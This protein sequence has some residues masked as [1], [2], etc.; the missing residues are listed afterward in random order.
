MTDMQL[1]KLDGLFHSNKGIIIDSLIENE[2][3]EIFVFF[4]QKLPKDVVVKLKQ[5]NEIRDMIFNYF[6]RNCDELIR[7]SHSLPSKSLDI[8]VE[9]NV[10]SSIS[11][12]SLELEET[13]LKNSWQERKYSRESLNASFFT[14]NIEHDSIVKC[15]IRDN[16]MKPRT[17][18]DLN[19]AINLP[20]SMFFTPIFLY[21]ASVEYLLKNILTKYYI[22][23]MDEEIKTIDMKIKVDSKLNSQTKC[24]SQYVENLMKKMKNLNEETID[25][26]SPSFLSKYSIYFD[27]L[28]ENITQL[29]S[30]TTKNMWVKQIQNEVNGRDT[31]GIR[32]ETFNIIAN[33]LSSI[34]D[35][36][37]LGYQYIENIK[38]ERLLI[39]REYEDEDDLSLPDERYQIQLTYYDHMKLAETRKIYRDKVFSCA[40]KVDHL[41]SI[42]DSKLYGDAYSIVINSNEDLQASY[43]T[44]VQECVSSSLANE[45]SYIPCAYKGAKEDKTFVNIKNDIRKNF[46]ISQQ[47]IEEIYG[48]KYSID[49]RVLEDRL[50]SLKKELN[51]ID[52][53]VN[54]FY[55]TPGF[56]L[57]VSATSIKRKHT[58]FVA[59]RSAIG[60]WLLSFKVA[61]KDMQNNF[62]KTEAKLS[63]K[64]IENRI[65]GKEDIKAEEKGKEDKELCVQEVRERKKRGRPKKVDI[66]RVEIADERKDVENTSSE[67]SKQPSYVKTSEDKENKMERKKV[68]IRRKKNHSKKK[69]LLREI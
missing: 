61:N 36:S 51:D 29:S 64:N 67:I 59:L 2:L 46:N 44:Y 37:T 6:A 38:T 53:L 24:T 16:T 7:K 5:N 26:E 13:E 19:L 31:E 47:R 43:K 11:T 62:I 57:D 8:G 45:D 22:N 39:L 12:G 18:S 56:L 33:N 42:I 68:D 9:R 14:E 55:I 32:N 27:V 35:T 30:E 25:Y 40:T 54:P 1:L 41:L 49:R 65:D 15:S 20:A 63:E 23:E 50:L 52:A 34:I 60:A 66:K 58:T 10:Q 3:S 4:Q 48:S 17:V 28:L 21:Q 69:P